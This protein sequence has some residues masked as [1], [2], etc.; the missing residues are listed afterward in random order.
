MTKNRQDLLDELNMA[1]SIIDEQDSIE[2]D[3]LRS[4]YSA[5]SSVSIFLS[6]KE[7]DWMDTH[8]TITVGYTE[9]YLPYCDKKEDGSVTG[10]IW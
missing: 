7:K 8:D 6:K 9:D 5:E 2:I 3:A 1:L 4:K 10:L